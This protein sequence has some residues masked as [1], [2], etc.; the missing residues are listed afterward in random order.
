MANEFASTS[1]AEPDRAGSTAGVTLATA[2]RVPVGA[3]GLKAVSAPAR[4]GPLPRQR[5]QVRVLVGQRAVIGLGVPGHELR[6]GCH[7]RVGFVFGI[8]AAVEADG[9]A[10]NP[11]V[12][13]EAN[14]FSVVQVS[15]DGEVVPLGR[16]ADILERVLVLVGPEVV[17][18]VE[19]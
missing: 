2:T 15:P 18:V 6:A 10:H 1:V 8:T 11:G 12:E 5:P 3:A 19:R 17:D 13:V 4:G 16:V 14:E 7:L 9:G